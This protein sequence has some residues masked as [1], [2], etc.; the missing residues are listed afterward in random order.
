MTDLRTSGAQGP[1]RN[2]LL[3]AG[4]FVLG[5]AG[6]CASAAAQGDKPPIKLWLIGTLSGFN[7]VLGED[8]KKGVELAIAELNS[9]GGID[10]RNVEL[11][12]ED[13]ENDAQKAVTAAH[14]L[15][16]SERV[17][18]IIGPM[19][20][21]YARATSSVTKE[22]KVVQITP[23]STMNALTNPINPYL[24]RIWVRDSDV[25]DQLARLAV[26]YQKIGI[27]YETTPWGQ[28][29]K[30]GLVEKLKAYKR[31]PASVQAFDIN[32]RDL[33]PQVSNFKKD[34]VDVVLIQAQGADAAQALRSMRQLGYKPQVLGHPGLTMASFA[35]LARNLANGT[36]VLDGID[37]SKPQVQR[38]QQAFKAKYGKEAWNFFAA[39]GY[40]A[41]MVLA[42]GFKNAGYDPAKLQAGMEMVKD[43]K[44]I[45]G[46]PNSTIT[47]SSTDHDG[48]GTTDMVL[49]RYSE[50]RMVVIKHENGKL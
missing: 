50:G 40:D 14:R 11:K 30:D 46:G 19:H 28:G 47:Y 38:F 1:R 6:L 27:L 20:S 15:I 37:S 7:S 22:S 36:V 49:K 21:A 26:N 18:A 43:Y 44:G 41:V 31:E 9:R 23:I 13:D 4:S 3:L 32:S 42:E 12:S 24:F 33:T 8:T 48:Y 17:T 2:L 10:G 35:E 25:A 16:D 34:G 45:I 39:A 29:G 5:V